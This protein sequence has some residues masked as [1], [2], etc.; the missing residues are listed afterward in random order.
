MSRQQQVELDANL[1]QGHL[2]LTADVPTLR[3]ALDGVYAHLY[4]L[5]Y[6]QPA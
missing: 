6:G 5:Q 4:H 3:A 2:D 1:R